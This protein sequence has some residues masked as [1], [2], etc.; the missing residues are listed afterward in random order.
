MGNKPILI[1]ML[2]CD[3]ETVSNAYQ[4][5]DECK[6]TKAQYWGFKEKPLPIE[7][8]KKLY[9]YMKSCGKKTVLEV[10]EY[11]EKECLEG[12]QMAIECGCDMLMGT[13]FFDSVNELCKK[14]GLKYC[15][16][17]G[18]LRERPTVMEGEVEKMIADAREYISKG[19]YGIDLLGYRYMGDAFR[20]IDEF[21]SSIDAPVCVA[22]SINSYDRL[23]EIKRISPRAFTI[24]SAFFNKCFGESF[25]MQIDTVCD[26]MEQ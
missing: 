13:V 15:P 18:E 6:D 10:V 11:T 16:F 20:L 25:G 22:G 12:A 5:F 9:A 23:D 14:H 17:V 8:M 21:V 26:Y 1:V 2:T 3:D 7:E 24:G 4:L 19:A